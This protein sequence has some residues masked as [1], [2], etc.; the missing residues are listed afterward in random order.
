MGGRDEEV[1][2]VMKEIIVRKR[3]IYWEAFFEEDG[4]GVREAL[5]HMHALGLL[6]VTFPDR[7][8]VHIKH[9]RLNHDD[10]V[11]TRGITTKACRFC[12]NPI[13]WKGE[14]QG[15]RGYSEGLSD[16]YK[17]QTKCIEKTN[18]LAKFLEGPRPFLVEA[19]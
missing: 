19:P 8:G 5:T 2:E 3:G 17:H 12:S 7:L 10:P 15:D 4:V 1:V 11:Q 18:Y 13:T 6:V 14:K 16:Y 9:D